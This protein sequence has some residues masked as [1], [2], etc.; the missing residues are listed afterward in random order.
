MKWMM[1][2]FGVIFYNFASGLLLYFLTSSS[3]GILESWMIRKELARR[4]EEAKESAPRPVLAGPGSGKKKPGGGGG[5][6]KKSRGAAA[7]R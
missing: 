3:L 1:V 4:E 2:F 5:G 7:R 6:K